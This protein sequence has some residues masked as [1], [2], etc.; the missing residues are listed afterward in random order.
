M[1]IIPAID[2]KDGKVVR[3]YKGQFDKVTE[4]GSDPVEMAKH[5]EDMGAQYLHVVDLDGAK[6]GSRANREVIKRLANEVHILIEVGGG[7]RTQDDI[8]ELLARID[9]VRERDLNAIRLQRG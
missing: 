8:D 6:S 9:E 4:Y 7:I 2:I 5:W 3:L 1:L